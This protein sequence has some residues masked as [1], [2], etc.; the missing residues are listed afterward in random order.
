[1]GA[2]MESVLGLAGRD[3][4]SA[5]LVV[6]QPLQEHQAAE[7]GEGALL[8][9][10]ARLG[11]GA[12]LRLEPDRNGL[13]AQNAVG[14]TTKRIR[15]AVGSHGSTSTIEE[16]K[17][18]QLEHCCEI[19]RA[20]QSVSE[21]S[22]ALL[23]VRLREERLR[24]SLSQDE[25]GEG[26]GVSRRTVVAWEKGDQAPNGLFLAYAAERGVDV[27]YVLTGQHAWQMKSEAIGAF[28]SN[29]ETALLQHY[30]HADAEGQRVICL[31][32]ERFGAKSAE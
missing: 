23:G 32:A 7:A 31:V 9:S 6:G 30:R 16:Q 24:L 1:M 28:L 11:S 13:V 15:D 18:A 19:N 27:N 21:K 12:F 3:A 10:G 5:V 22:C 4:A 14:R 17:I 2:E 26:G 25:F 20:C 29:E 8:L